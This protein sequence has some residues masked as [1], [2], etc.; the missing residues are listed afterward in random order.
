MSESKEVTI[1]SLYAIVQREV[2]SDTVQEL[3]PDLFGN[4]AEFIGNLKKQEFDNIENKIKNT[5]VDLACELVDL[6][7]K[8]RL[9]KNR[10]NSDFVNMLD[11]EKY[12]LDSEEEYQ[13]RTEMVLSAM[14]NGKSKLLDS[15]SDSHKTKSAAVRFL[16]DVDEF[17]GADLEK[18][19]P[20][21]AEDLAT[22]P[23]DNA[24][25]LILQKSAIKIRL[26]D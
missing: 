4:I 13:D 25:A 1:N 9:E 18:Y 8:V 19:G 23:Y 2:Q 11:V 16:K 14:L 12:I 6:L 5:L 3:D 20:F 17:V 26:D 24:Q 15:I 21:K 7:V 10:N 22:I